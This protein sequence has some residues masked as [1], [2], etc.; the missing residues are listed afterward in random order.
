LISYLKIKRILDFVFALIM[1]FLLS[2][3]FITLTIYIKIDSKGA[4]FFRQKRIGKNKM[5]FYILKFR[6]MR[7][8]SPKDMPTHLL[9]NP[10]KF[11]TKAGKFLRKTSLDELPQIMNILKGCMSFIGPRPALWN[12]YD[13]IKIRD[14][15]GVN[16]VNPGITGWA[17]VNGRDELS[18]EEKAKYDS[19]YVENLNVNFDIKVL[20]KTI[21]SVLLKKGVVEG[22]NEK[23]A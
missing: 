2:P 10:D 21:S 14:R 18:I 17:Q 6:T 13:L 12:Q 23:C 3:I 7:I 5:E 20:I 9:Q 11:I 1:L 15:Y 4:V 19:E 16:D 22:S 8:D